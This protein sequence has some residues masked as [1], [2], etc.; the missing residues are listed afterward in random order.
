LQPGETGV[1]GVEPLLE[2]VHPRLRRVAPHAEQDGALVRFELV[3]EQG[4][5]VGRTKEPLLGARELP[6]SG[7]GSDELGLRRV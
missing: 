2:L 5:G 7:A 4:G 1:G 6:S 3:G